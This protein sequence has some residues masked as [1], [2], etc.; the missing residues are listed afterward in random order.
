MIQ[1]EPYLPGIP[2]FL[3]A[4]SAAV[5]M[6]DDAFAKTI[7]GKRA[8]DR[9]DVADRDALADRRDD[10]RPVGEADVDRTLP[11]ERHEVGVDLVLERDIERRPPRSS[12]ACCAR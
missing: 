4:R 11:D 10:A 2:I 9:R 7:D 3:P 6:P 12:P 8:V 5:V 1:D